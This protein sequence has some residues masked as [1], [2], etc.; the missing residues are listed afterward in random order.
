[1]KI[2]L[3]VITVFLEWSRVVL[4]MHLPV[5]SQNTQNRVASLI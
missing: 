4:M 1:V 5:L 3:V 2:I